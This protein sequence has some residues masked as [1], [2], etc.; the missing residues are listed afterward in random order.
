MSTL[1]EKSM[2]RILIQI[3]TIVLI[4]I[5]NIN[6]SYAA[7]IEVTCVADG[8]G[9]Q[10][11]MCIWLHPDNPELSTII[12]SDKSRS[13]LFVYNLDGEELYS[14][15]LQHKPG[16]IDIIYNFPFNGELIDLVGFNKR[17]TSDARFVFYKVDKQTRELISI[18]APLTTNS[19]SAELYGFCL[20]NSPNNDE[21]YAFVPKLWLAGWM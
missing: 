3:T 6:Y 14:Y 20:Y 16:N 5:L 15:S 13:K 17:T 10:D 21:F 18:G 7:E 1:K 9:D 19:W 2:K 4:T 12:A 11:D 8:A